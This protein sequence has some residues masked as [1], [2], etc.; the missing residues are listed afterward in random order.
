MKYLALIH[1]FVFSLLIIDD[2]LMLYIVFMGLSLNML[3]SLGAL[4]TTS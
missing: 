1:S 4:V 2:I 3:Q